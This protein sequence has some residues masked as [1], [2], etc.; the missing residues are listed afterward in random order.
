MVDRGCRAF[1]GAKKCS[2]GSAGRIFEVK[3]WS[4][5]A[6]EHFL[7]LKSVRQPLPAHKISRKNYS[8][9]GISH[10]CRA[11][12]PCPFRQRKEEHQKVGRSSYSGK[13]VAPIS[14]IKRWWT[15]SNE[16]MAGLPMNTSCSRAR[17][18]A[19]FSFRSITAPCSTKDWLQRNWS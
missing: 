12:L 2:A 15:S 3:K 7:W 8:D 14:S 6:A 13:V 5:E 9:V 1:P 16:R 11:A 18:R 10:I 19:T 4:A 17:V